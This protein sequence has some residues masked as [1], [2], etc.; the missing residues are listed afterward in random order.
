MH[1][2][3]LD[4]IREAYSTVEATTQTEQGLTDFFERKLGV[5]QGC[6]L[7]PK[8]LIIFINEVD[9]MLKRSECRGV[10]MD[11]AI[12]VFFIVVCGCYCSS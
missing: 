11:N 6:M 12:E 10:S 4:S 7:S 1:D 9:I 8:L 2:R 5:R 3:M